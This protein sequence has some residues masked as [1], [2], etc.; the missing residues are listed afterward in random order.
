MTEHAE[1]E[2]GMNRTT[3]PFRADHVGSLL[4][5]AAAPAGARGLRGRDDRRRRAARGRGRRDPRRG[6][7]AGGGRAAGGRP[8]ASS[9][10]PRGTWTSSTRSTA[11]ARRPATSPFSSTTSTATSSSRR[12]RC[13]STQARHLE[14]DL[15]RRLR[16]PRRRRRRGPSQADDPVAEHGPLPRR[17]GRD[18]P[19]GVRR[20]GLVLGRPDAAYA[21]RC[22][23]S[24]SS[25]APTCSSTTRASPT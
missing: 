7:Q 16:V 6:A 12:P 14:D 23:G 9:A 4:R 22:G 15:R 10:A 13:T 25:A 18:R 17:Q 19:G 2:K 20:P 8:T 24:A 21:R 1:P 5:A 11:S 3:P